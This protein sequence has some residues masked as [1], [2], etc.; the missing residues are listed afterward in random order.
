MRTGHV[1]AGSDNIRVSTIAGSGSVGGANGV[2]TA[3]TFS[4]AFGIAIDPSG[5]A[6]VSESAGRRVRQLVVSTGAVTTLAGSGASA[7]TDGTGTAAAFSELFYVALDGLGN[8]FVCDFGAHRIRKVVLATHAVTT[9]AGSGTA[10]FADGAG[11]AAS[12]NN[13]HGIACDVNGNAYVSDGGNNC[14][15]KIVLSS[16]TVTTLAGSAA[17]S[18]TNGVGTAAGFNRPSNV[19]VSG[20]LLFVAEWNSHLVRQIV[21]ATQTVT[22]LAGS[23]TS[24]SANG[25]GVAAQFNGAHGLAVDSRGNLFVG[26]IG[27]N[28]IRK[29][30]IATQTVTTVAGTGAASW[31]DGF[32][33][34]AAFSNPIGLAVDS[35]GNVF[36]AESGNHRVRV[37]QPSVPCPAGVYCA[38]GA[39]AVACTPG[40]FC[41]LGADRV[42]CAAGYFC[43]S[44]SS[45]QVVCPAGAFHCPAGA[46]AP[47]SIACAAGYIL[48]DHMLRFMLH[49]RLYLDFF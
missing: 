39:E 24:G 7:S 46:S 33:T 4:N 36:V 47:L 48:F 43:P 10:S 3:V 27:S 25:V 44:G 35:R 40:Y 11:T 18:A 26:D 1:T 5:I 2:G 29:I 32:G 19:V 37:M 9:V 16:A 31:A 15:R 45:A 14:I 8:M 30:V 34:N 17:P 22:T 6:Y 20:A 13:P 42:P 21:I 12:F 23:G 49:V 41:A 38:P 28:L